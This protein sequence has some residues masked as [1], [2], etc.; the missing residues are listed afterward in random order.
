MSGGKY[1][2]DGQSTH[3]IWLSDHLLQPGQCVRVE[4]S[5]H[6]DD[7]V[8]GK[9]LAELFPDSTSVGEGQD[10][11]REDVIDSLRQRPRFRERYTLAVRASSG[12]SRTATA[13]EVEHGFGASFLWNAVRPDRMSASLHTYSLDQLASQE[14]FTY[15]FRERLCPDAWAEL[16]ATE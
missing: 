7:S 8:V 16:T 4:F 6:G 1:P 14:G 5:S 15:H 10:L 9:T 3:L 12:D 11:S 2:T 13:T